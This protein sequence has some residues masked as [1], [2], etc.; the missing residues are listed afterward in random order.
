[1]VLTELG[2]FAGSFPLLSRGT[3]APLSKTRP[4]N[5]ALEASQVPMEVAGHSFNASETINFSLYDSF[6]MLGLKHV[7]G[8]GPNPRAWALQIQRPGFKS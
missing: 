1:M 6:K 4:A 2:F 7:L 8:V 5:M 3:L